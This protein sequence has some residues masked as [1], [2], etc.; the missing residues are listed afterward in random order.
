MNY[1]TF[2][3][4]KTPIKAWTKGVVFDENSKAQLANI[5]S[6][7]FIHKWIAVMPD[8]H[9]GKGATIG[10]V[11]PTVSA[12]IPAAVGVDIGCGMMAVRTS[13]QAK[14]LP[15]NLYELRSAIERAIPHGR[16]PRKRNKR[17]KGAWNGIPQDVA[18]AWLPLQ[19]QFDLLKAKHSV[20]AK[21][22]NVNHLGTLGTGNHFIEVCL[23]EHDS[24]WFMLHS[25][26]RGV[27][28]RIGT[29]FIELAKK[30]MERAQI[31]LPDA[32]LA[33]LKEGSEVF[34]D[35][36]NAVQWA[37]DYA[38]VN[39]HL[40]M[41]RL[42]DVV[43][44][45]LDMQFQASL[46]AVNCHHNYVNREIHYGQQVYLTRKGA[47][48]AKKG[49]L[50]IIPGSMGARSFIVRGLGNEESFCSCSHGAGRVMS[51]TKAKKLV[52]IE[53]HIRDTRG[54]ECRKDLSV[55]DETPSAY[56]DIDKVMQAQ[57]SL[58]QIVYTLKQVVCVKG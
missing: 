20:L 51:R 23:D 47:V 10:S 46:E 58:V 8:V 55:I 13:L 9:L 18:N 11:I 14:Q 49:E 25:G 34:D 57:S 1:E 24:V 36:I 50:G 33:Y 7:P 15:D 48:S 16:S 40:M 3:K 43:K 39:R 52:S 32:D 38:R 30:D 26:S 27:G 56:K 2:N 54:V 5:A 4:S 19:T 22:N 41:N 35:Y 31:H 53:E 42:I 37:Q 28:N 17:D 45:T 6:L 21:T 44:N 12:I 29:Y